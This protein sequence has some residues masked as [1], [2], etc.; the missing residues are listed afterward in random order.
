V[1]ETVSKIRSRV[2]EEEPD[3]S[4]CM[5]TCV[6]THHTIKI[7]VTPFFKLF[8]FILGALVF[9]GVTFPGT[10]VADINEPPC[11][12][13]EM[14]SGLLEEQPVLLTTEP[15][16]QPDTL[17]SM[18]IFSPCFRSISNVSTDESP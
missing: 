9:E 8:I 17:F 7:P 15:S 12:C 10:G 5:C 2:T 18:S 3:F 1:R 6:H 14:N 13:W 4:A 11:G 16:L